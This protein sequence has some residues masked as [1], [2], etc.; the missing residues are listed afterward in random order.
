MQ[1][2]RGLGIVQ[3]ISFPCLPASILQDI[4]ASI[5]A[6]REINEAMIECNIPVF[7]TDASCRVFLRA[8]FYHPILSLIVHWRLPPCE[9]FQRVLRDASSRN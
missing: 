1:L 7:L 3:M 2:A 9:S 4:Q 8:L 6:V 5:R